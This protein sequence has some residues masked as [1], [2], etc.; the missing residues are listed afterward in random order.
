MSY[1]VCGFCVWV[2]KKTIYFNVK[3]NWRARV[4]E[5]VYI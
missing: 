3:W 5:N 1:F 4:V 2:N